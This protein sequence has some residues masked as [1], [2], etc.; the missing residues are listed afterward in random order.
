M[1]WEE[2][3]ETYDLNQE[4][5]KPRK[6]SK[7]GSA[8]E[9]ETC[10]CSVP[11]G[12]FWYVN[13]MYKEEM[14]RIEKE[15]GVK[16][17]AE[18]KLKFQVDK[19]HGSPDNALKEFENLMQNS[20]TESSGS[21]IPLKF[22]DPDQWRDALKTIQKSKKKLLVTLTCET[23]TVQGPRHSQ[24]VISKSLFAD[25]VQHTNTRAFL[26]E[27]EKKNLDTSLK[28]DRTT[29]DLWP[30]TTS[31]NKE[32][33]RIKAGFNVEIKESDINQGK[34]SVKTLHKQ[35]EGHSFMKDCSLK[36]AFQPY[37]M[38]HH[39]LLMK[40]NCI[41]QL[42]GASND[43]VSNDQSANRMH[44]TDRPTDSGTTAGDQ[45]DERCPI[46]LDRF[47]NKKQLKCKDEFCEDCLRQ[48]QDANGP[49]CPVCR[50]VFGKI[51]GDQPDGRMSHQTLR[52]SLPGYSDCGTIVIN[53]VIPS[54]IQTAKHP[55]PGQLYSGIHRTAYLPDNKEGNEVLQLLKRAFQQ[56]LIFTVGTSRTTG[57]DNQ[58]T[59]NDIPHKTS[60]SG[61][62][63]RFGYPD[64]EYLSRVKEELKAKGI[65]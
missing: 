36:S 12:H 59:W 56:R 50:V 17:E 14:K 47:K 7:A 57:L 27:Y 42:E 51:I 65:E 20:I 2:P 35:D 19:K 61:G 46:C 25:T 15:N 23:M 49:I 60:T 8:A 34:V 63:D 13:H 64:P 21:V 11:V 6:R 38:T 44:N 43:P 31:C 33:D 24:D 48:A 5:V 3:M 28:T 37:R 26:E 1:N 41:S 4:H 52:T 32:V 22:I 53:Y 45:K 40:T 62:P 16:I 10:S 55:N 9:E 30:M 18:L 58:V 39:N 54:G 29:K